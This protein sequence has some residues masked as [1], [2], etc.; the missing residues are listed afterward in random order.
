MSK[1]IVL[2]SREV[3]LVDDEDFEALNSYSWHVKIC[4]NI[5]YAM[6]YT[7]EEERNSGYPKRASMHRQVMDVIGNPNIK[8]DHRD[9]NGLNNQRNNLRIAT[10]LQNQM[11]KSTT[12]GKSS[13]YKGVCWSSETSKW[14][15]TIQLNG[16]IHHLG[17]F[18]N[19]ADAALAYN[20]KA[21]ELFGEYASL[22]KIEGGKQ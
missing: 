9:R 10:P 1:E 5:M 21:L 22:N 15:A 14:R 3:A 18:R 4:D 17:Y 16:K 12:S 13:I 6:R 2:P 19:E 11:N 7:T 8:V 20:N